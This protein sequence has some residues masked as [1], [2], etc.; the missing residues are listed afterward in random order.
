MVRQSES[1]IY[2]VGSRHTMYLKT[3]L[4]NDSNFPFH[5]GESLIV[6]IEDNKLIIER[7]S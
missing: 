6:R 4:V 5:V 3:D 1:K 2:K 7:K